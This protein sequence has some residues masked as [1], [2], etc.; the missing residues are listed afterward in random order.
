ML[1][2]LCHATDS[3]WKAAGIAQVLRNFPYVFTWAMDSQET[4]NHLNAVEEAIRSLQYVVGNVEKKIVG[5]PD[6]NKY[7][8]VISWTLDAARS[9]E[10]GTSN[11]LESTRTVNAQV[12]K[13]NESYPFLER[14]L[15]KYPRAEVSLDDIAPSGQYR[16]ECRNHIVTVDANCRLGICKLYMRFQGNDEDVVDEGSGYYIGNR[17]V[18]TAAHCLYDS[19]DKIH[20]TEVYACIG[21]S[22]RPK[23]SAT[24]PERRTIISV[25]V[26]WGYYTLGK[27][28]YD[29]GII[30]LD[31]DFDESREIMWQTTPQ[32]AN[33]VL[34][35][36]VGYPGDLPE[37]NKNL[38]GKV[39]YASE[40]EVNFLDIKQDDYELKYSL[41]T[42]GG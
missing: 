10:A 18:I 32:Q 19:E 39:M 37:G 28:M 14:L 34:L 5:L 26:H 8:V 13:T 27:T 9:N 22:G 15:G 6:F 35:R 11:A 25:A 17:T 29:V 31:S 20:A 42:F 2:D 16:G 21:F 24:K 30:K 38:K 12:G 7:T 36:V 1:W 23:T 4:E 40:C 33:N 41:D 3:E